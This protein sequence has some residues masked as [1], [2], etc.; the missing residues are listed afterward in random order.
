MNA[1]T[2]QGR[3]IWKRIDEEEKLFHTDGSREHKSD[4]R[5]S[6]TSTGN[7]DDPATIVTPPEEDELKESIRCNSSPK[8]T[9]A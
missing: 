1:K 3:E 9:Q 5:K 2:W 6:G 7:N 8:F 4:D